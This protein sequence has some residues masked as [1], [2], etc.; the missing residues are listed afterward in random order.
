MT[1]YPTEISPLSRRNDERPE[2]VDRFELFVARQEIANGFSELNDPVDQAARFQAQADAKS[3][4]DDEAMFF[5][6]DY[7]RALSYGMPPTAGEGIGVDRLAMLLTG[8]TSIR[9]VVL[10]PALRQKASAP[11]EDDAE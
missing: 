7:V 8:Q 3:S 2:I 11:A 5:D 9:E 1:G 4:G 6:A 10:F